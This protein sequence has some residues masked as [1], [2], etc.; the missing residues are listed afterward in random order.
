M[1]QI[2]CHEPN[3]VSAFLSS[4]ILDQHLKLEHQVNILNL[5][6]NKLTCIM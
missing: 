5:D 4:E 6:T 1:K 2:S 3:P